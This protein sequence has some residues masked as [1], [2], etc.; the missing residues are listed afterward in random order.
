L[1]VEAKNVEGK[2]T[3]LKK[4]KKSVSGREEVG[5]EPASCGYG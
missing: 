2:E 3:A 5:K 1:K 4:E